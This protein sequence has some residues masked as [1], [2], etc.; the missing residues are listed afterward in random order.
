MTAQNIIGRI[1]I[2][3][4]DDRLSAAIA[5]S[6]LGR[7]GHYFPLFEDP[8]TQRPDFQNE[9]VKR[10]N[11]FRLVQF[12]FEGRCNLMLVNLDQSTCRA[13][14]RYLSASEVEI[15]ALKELVD[16]YAPLQEKE[17]AIPFREENVLP[18][19]FKA[20][21]QNKSLVL[22]QAADTLPVVNEHKSRYLV[23]VEN[24]KKLGS[25]VGVNYACFLRAHLAVIRESSAEEVERITRDFRRFDEA[26]DGLVKEESAHEIANDLVSR[27]SGI[28]FDP[29]EAVIFFS[30]GIPYGSIIRESATTHFPI[31]PEAGLF[32]LSSIVSDRPV[33]T[34]LVIDPSQVQQSETN[35]VVSELLTKNVYTKLLKGEEATITEVDFHITQLPYDLILISSH[36]CYP[37]GARLTINFPDSQGRT[38]VLIIRKADSFS[39]IPFTDQIRVETF[40]EL[41]FIDGIA[42]SSEEKV[43]PDTMNRVIMRLD[44]SVQDGF[45]KIVARK[46]NV[47]MKYC[48]AIRLYDD[49]YFVTFQT[50]QVQGPLI[51]VNTCGSFQHMTGHFVYGGVSYYIGTTVSVLDSIAFA[52]AKHLLTSEDNLVRAIHAF[53][54]EFC[55]HLHFNIYASVGSPL[56]TIRFGDGAS[57]EY[58]RTELK[59]SIDRMKTFNSTNPLSSKHAQTQRLIRRMESELR[60]L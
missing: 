36:G 4:E 16:K 19:L 20:L 34:A 32:T 47:E 7:W 26:K 39:P 45:A 50:Q 37:N 33:R 8:R 53:N 23:V 43:C 48:N 46:E 57:T 56:R 5:S 38:H 22:D 27:L 21:I 17:D 42:W 30:Q 54:S 9:V 31:Y 49:N 28:S 44:E 11:L 41:E 59:K 3:H 12:N 10:V 13:I 35:F 58:F 52:F 51:L 6:F 55:S 24:S 18:A 15:L 60:Q 2:F 29:Y 25:I 1:A 40:T 14:N